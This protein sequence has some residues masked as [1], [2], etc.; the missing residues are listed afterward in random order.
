MAKNPSFFKLA[1]MNDILLIFAFFISQIA[2][3]VYASSSSSHDCSGKDYATILEKVYS[4]EPSKGILGRDYEVRVTSFD[5]A[6]DSEELKDAELYAPIGSGI[7]VNQTTKTYGCT[8]EALISVA[9]DAQVDKVQ[10]WVR[11]KEG[12]EVLGTAE[13]TI[14]RLPPGPI[15]PGL[16]PQ[17]DIMWSLIPDKIVGHNFGRNIQNNYYCMEVVLGNN[18]GYSLQIVSVG[19]EVPLTDGELL[20]EALAEPTPSPENP[21][22]GAPKP[23]SKSVTLVTKSEPDATPPLP[24]G[25]RFLK[26][27]NSSYR[28]T[29]G[30][31]ESRHLLYPRSFILSTI[32]AL[33]PIF[34]GFTPFFH[35]INHRGN[36]TEAIN[37]FSNPLEKGL[38]MAW[39]DPREAQ[40]NRFDDQILRDGLIVSNNTSTRTMVF[41]PKTLLK[42][43]LDVVAVEK[44][45][46]RRFPGDVDLS[47]C[48]KTLVKEFDKT[49]STW[50]NNPRAVI[51]KL[52]KL[53]LVGDI[54]SA[55]NRITVTSGPVPGPL[56][57]P[58]SL[59]DVTLDKSAMREVPQGKEGVL[60]IIGSR[61]NGAH[62]TSTSDK[63]TISPVTTDTAGGMI[64]TTMKVADDAPP[65]TYTLIVST[66]AG[67]LP[68]RFRVVYKDPPKDLKIIKYKNLS[69]GS[70]SEEPLTL[71][72]DRDHDIQITIEGENLK[73][74]ELTL[75]KADAGG[76]GL[77]RLDNS[78]DRQIVATIRVRDKTPPKKYPITV[79]NSS[80]QSATI[81]DFEIKHEEQ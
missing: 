68:V 34:T 36:F 13:F 55:T 44:I 1:R 26:I 39:P 67:S 5:C 38:E 56:A 8:L 14:T 52:G 37:I 11:K 29:R 40:R 81:D 17:V 70:E 33:G 77:I 2:P 32:T 12:H 41:F 31:L 60:E 69:D 71:E 64:V 76:L 75:P 22:T 46:K 50:K 49:Y 57:A 74:A 66:S 16:T 3:S 21:K 9:G 72:P 35:N 61:L 15:P 42:P 24:H 30:S 45:C 79:T 53:I 27:P 19:F 54:I 7:S 59:L 25:S 28:L 80:S 78:D 47:S 43:Y 73:D 6:A 18:T 58:P 62:I 48:K 51:D 4:V 65:G 20:K 23:R 63:I 10:L